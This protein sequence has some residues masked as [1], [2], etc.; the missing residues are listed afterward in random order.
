MGLEAGTE[1]RPTQSERRA[2][3]LHLSMLVVQ[4]FDIFEAWVQSHMCAIS[5]VC[6]KHV[7]S[8]YMHTRSPLPI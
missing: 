3:S 2:G 8:D 7:H 4:L 5:Y 6:T 1:V